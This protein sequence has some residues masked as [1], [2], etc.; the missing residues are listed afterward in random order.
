MASCGSE[1]EQSS[2]CPRG[3]I[4]SGPSSLALRGY[5]HWRSQRPASTPSCGRHS[6]GQRCRCRHRRRRAGPRALARPRRCPSLPCAALR[7][8]ALRIG[9]GGEP[10]SGGL[11]ADCFR[12]RLLRA[13]SH[14]AWGCFCARVFMQSQ[15]AIRLQGS[16]G[17]LPSPG[18]EGTSPRGCEL[19]ADP[20]PGARLPS[21]ECFLTEWNKS[22]HFMPAR[23]PPQFSTVGPRSRREKGG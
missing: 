23:P 15:A 1:E 17:E 20:F 11:A 9:G 13:R 6:K 12:R 16:R 22:L 7:F 18:E 10:R 5:I 19:S 21:P 4:A 2:C 3:Y 8:A 14:G